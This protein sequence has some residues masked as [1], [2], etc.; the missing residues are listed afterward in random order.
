MRKA[1]RVEVA[2]TEATWRK[3]SRSGGGSGNACVEVA[4]A[5][6]AV[7]VRDSKAPH[8]PAL[9]FTPGAWRSFLQCLP[10]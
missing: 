5:G 1:A 10:H 8:G 7:A 4:F 9:A 6:S 3:S 2:S